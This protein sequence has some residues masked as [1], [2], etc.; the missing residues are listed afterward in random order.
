MSF[1]GA[2]E[3]PQVSGSGLPPLVVRRYM[4]PRQMGL[5]PLQGLGVPPLHEIVPA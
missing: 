4:A 5:L 1:V 3:S 2:P